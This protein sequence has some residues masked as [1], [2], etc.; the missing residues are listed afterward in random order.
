[1]N[2]RVTIIFIVV[3]VLLV[4]G[5][6]LWKRTYATKA[7]MAT[8]SD[9]R[10]ELEKTAP[11]A[12]DQRPPD[13]PKTALER[14]LAQ[15]IMV[16]YQRSSLGEVLADLRAQVGLQSAFPPG[17]DA[18]V[19]FTLHDTISVREIT[20]RLAANGRLTLTQHDNTVVFSR[21]ADD[22]VITLLTDASQ[23]GAQDRRLMALYMLSRLGDPRVCAP[24]F[25]AMADPDE[26][27]ANCAIT[28]ML[29]WPMS[30]PELTTIPV[31]VELFIARLAADDFNEHVWIFQMLGNSGDPRATAPLLGLLNEQA[32]PV[33]LYLVRNALC[34][35]HDPKSVEPLITLLQ[36]YQD[37]PRSIMLLSTIVSILRALDAW[38]SQYDGQKNGPTWP[39]A[40][41]ALEQ[42]GYPQDVTSLIAQL[43]KDRMPLIRI[44]AAEA[45]GVL[46]DPRAVDQ[47]CPLLENQ[48]SHLALAAA[49]ALGALRDRKATSFLIHALVNYES[50]DTRVLSAI[51][52]AIGRIG[53]PAAVE[54]LI[55]LLKGNTLMARRW[56]AVDAL[57]RL[58]QEPS[59]EPLIALLK[60]ANPETRRCAVKAL[61]RLRDPRAFEP[62]L[63]MLQDNDRQVAS[64]AYQALIAFRDSESLQAALTKTADAQTTGEIKGILSEINSITHQMPNF[65]LTE[66]KAQLG[67]Y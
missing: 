58:R 15:R 1:M 52:D 59:I 13:E 67:I 7:D 33:T 12:L 31:P 27:V 17:L 25:R 19:A 23:Q 42:A 28:S 9:S 11:P 45:L 20:E 26:K 54:T 35:L 61:G 36:E 44:G 40:T 21:K 50:P 34:A 65:S 43:G 38:G 5:L 62:L 37:Q 55:V 39:K 14:A 56:A 8:N 29:Q 51:G 66:V 57:I 32:K 63:Q 16:H 41:A 30:C 64:E 53:D 3:A 4:S 18:C 2:S 46:K 48:N 22:G 24:M 6:L 47:L 49:T 60:D 10:S